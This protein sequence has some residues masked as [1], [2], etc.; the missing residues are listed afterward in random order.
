MPKG[1]KAKTTIKPTKRTR[2]AKVTQ[3]RSVF[4][5]GKSFHWA[6]SYTSFLMGIVVVIVAALFIFS[7][8]KQTHNVQ[9]TSSTSTTVTPIPTNVTQTIFAPQE[10]TYTVKSG[11]DLWHISENVYKSGY[12]WVAIARANHLVNPG[13]IHAGNVLVLPTVT[14]EPTTITQTP[15]IITNSSNAITATVYTVRRG[16]DLWNIAV[17]AYGDGYKWTVIANA[18]HLTNP[19]L[20][21]SGNVLQLPR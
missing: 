17:R 1:R 15:T 2:V 18:N 12:N 9:Q 19:G 16:D 13:T 10:K 5:Q 4:P 6:E 7:F 20:I 3:K 21:F 8:I 14:P 11:D